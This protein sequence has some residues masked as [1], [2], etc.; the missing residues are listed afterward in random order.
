MKIKGWRGG[1][2]SRQDMQ[3]ESIKIK[4][5]DF[6]QQLWEEDVPSHEASE[7]LPDL[8]KRSH[9]AIVMG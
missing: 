1:G 5:V 8:S 6:P 3:F 7:I 9:A 2:S 4:E